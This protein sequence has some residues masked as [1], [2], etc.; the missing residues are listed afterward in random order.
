MAGLHEKPIFLVSSPRSGS[1]LFRLIMDSH[2]NIAVPP[3]AWLYDFFQPYIYSYGDTA[4]PENLTAMAQDMIDCPTIQRWAESFTVDQLVARAP[5]PTFP[6]LY[7]ALHLLYAETKGKPRWGEKSPRNA[8]WVNEIKNDFAGAQFIHLIRDGRDAAMDLAE[9]SLFPETLYS[10]ANVWQTWVSSIRH[11]AKSLSAE[12]YLEVKY[13]DFCADPESHLRTVCDFIGEDYSPLML[14]HS[15]TESAKHW[16]KSDTLHARTSRPISTEYCELYKALAEN[17][18]S[19]IEF[20]IG[21][22]LEELGYA[23]SMPESTP[24]PH[25]VRQL[26]AADSITLLA[27]A[28]F[29]PELRKRRQDRL[30]KGVWKVEDREGQIWG[31]V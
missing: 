27:N 13:E 3:P 31:F 8:L 21:D 26:L 18:R 5:E 19:L 7:D 9:S 6:G 4:V 12:S 24:S 25:L 29:K 2:P 1:T 16:G 30:D 22:L 20:L 17:D 23:R 28:A 11:S 14:Q 15:E 10:G